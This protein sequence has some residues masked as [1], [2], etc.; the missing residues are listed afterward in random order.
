MKHFIIELTFIILLIISI[1][2]M[3]TYLV[4]PSFGKPAKSDTG[5]FITSI[6]IAIASICILLTLK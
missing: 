4:V 2:V 6:I 3:F 1:G 5:I